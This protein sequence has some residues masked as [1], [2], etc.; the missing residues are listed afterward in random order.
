MGN[1][2]DIHRRPKRQGVH[3]PAVHGLGR[4]KSVV[5]DIDALGIT[6]ANQHEKQT[7]EEQTR[8]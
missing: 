5:A 6:L 2:R 7:Y 1:F 3:E 8:K 4:V